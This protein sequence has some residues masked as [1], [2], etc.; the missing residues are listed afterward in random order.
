[1]HGQTTKIKRYY[2]RELFFK[3]WQQ[4]ADW[5]DNH[6]GASDADRI[7]ARRTIETAVLGEIK[8]LHAHSTEVSVFRDVPSR[9]DRALTK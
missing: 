5:N 4:T 7:T 2:W 3:E 6:P 8:A 1:M 9:S